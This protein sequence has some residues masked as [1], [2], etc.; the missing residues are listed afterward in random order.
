MTD[1]RKNEPARG[2][3]ERLESNAEFET[4]FVPER[5]S[6]M[7]AILP[8]DFDAGGASDFHPDADPLRDPAL[9][10]ALRE[11]A[12][13][14]APCPEWDRMRR[15]ILA[16]AAPRLAR[17]RATAHWWQHASGWASHA[18]PIGLA[19]SVVLA[20]GLHTLAPRGLEPEPT[21][22]AEMAFE[23]MLASVFDEAREPTVPADG[24]ELLRAALPIE[25]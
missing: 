19:A 2:Q 18:I 6:D 16:A 11:L 3:I 15:S 10:S 14:E 13:G 23:S 4:E 7:D 20:F 5:E 12:G 17:R 24:D 25:N 9:A 21:A 22:T 8:P 1:E